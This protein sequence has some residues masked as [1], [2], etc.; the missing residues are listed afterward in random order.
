MHYFNVVDRVH[1][2]NIA[3]YP[4][5]QRG[6]MIIVLAFIQNENPGGLI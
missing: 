5:P 1:F 4:Q 2:S 3:G 6:A